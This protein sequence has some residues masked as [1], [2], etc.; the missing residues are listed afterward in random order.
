ML[1]AAKGAKQ[2]KGAAQA[3]DGKLQ[4]G[5]PA[6]AIQQLYEDICQV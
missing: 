2:R 3:A 6:E 4:A 1:S 5:Q